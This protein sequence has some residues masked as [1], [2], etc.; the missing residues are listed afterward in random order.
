MFLCLMR[1][2]KAEI[3]KHGSNDSQR[4]LTENGRQ[5]VTVMA[6]LAKRWWPAGNTI[7]WSSPLVRARETAIIMGR[8]IHA[9]YMDIHPSIAVGDLRSFYQEVLIKEKN[10]VV[11]VVGHEPFLGH[12]AKEITGTPIDFKTG[13]IA[14][15]E[16]DPAAE[17]AGHG[18]LLLYVQPKAATLIL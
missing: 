9:V 5:R 3:F 10:D 4:H 17:P 7:I 13:S 12:W 18:K 1:H 15:F 8:A 2:G 6:S 14:I 16:Y 11:L